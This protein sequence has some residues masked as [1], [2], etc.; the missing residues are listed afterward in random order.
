MWY[1]GT[2]CGFGCFRRWGRGAAVWYV[3]A[4][5]AFAC[6]RRW[7]RRTTVWHIGGGSRR[8][9]VWY[10]GVSWGNVSLCRWRR[11]TAWWYVGT[12]CG[13][14]GYGERGA[15]LVVGQ[16]DAFRREVAVLLELGE[17]GAEG[18]AARAGLAVP[19]DRGAPHVVGG[20]LP[21]VGAAEQL[22]EDAARHVAQAVVPHGGIGDLEE[23]SRQPAAPDSHVLSSLAVVAGQGLVSGSG[24][25]GFGRARFALPACPILPWVPLHRT[26]TMWSETIR[27]C[28]SVVGSATLSA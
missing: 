27:W 28:P 16:G 15:V 26:G 24:H 25:G 4:S 12:T 1:V 17:G 13:N 20:R 14:V 22:D 5:W 2:T 19:G 10:V 8:T 11:R 7:R 9:S 6:F 23:V 21:A 3:G 18:A